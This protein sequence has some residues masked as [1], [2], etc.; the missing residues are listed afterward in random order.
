MGKEY[1]GVNGAE[2]L[3]C[4]LKEIK[5]RAILLIKS[6]NPYKA[7]EIEENL[8]HLPSDSIFL[9]TGKISYRTSDA[10]EKIMHLLKQFL[11]TEFTEYSSNP[12]WEDI[13]KG[14]K[15]WKSIKPSVIIALGGGSTLDVAKSIALLAE[16]NDAPEL[17]LTK[18]KKK[19]LAPRKIPFIAIPTTAGTGSEATYFATI[20]KDKVKLS[21]AHPSLL[22]DYVILDPLF[23]LSLSSHT[24]ACTGMDA[25]CQAIESYWSVHS[26]EESKQFAKRAIALALLNLEKAVTNPTIEVRSGMLKAANLAGKAINISFTTACHAVSYPITSYFGIPHGHAV[27]LTLPEM[28]QYNAEVTGEDCLD[29]RGVE[30]VRQTMQELFELFGV[31]SSEGMKNKIEAL[32]DNLG[33][34]RNLR[35]LGVLTDDDLNIIIKNGFN[36]DRVKNNPRKVSSDGL[37][38]I[39]KNIF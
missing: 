35:K 10:E 30:Y 28:I 21:L 7:Y 8:E 3:N 16:Q 4:L 5:P 2:E 1:F 11:L 38:K 27:A 34:E 25:L 12:L 37:L 23:T 36:P 6:K 14:V 19:I 33:L 17:Y 22:P 24:T 15:L 20:Y 26:T 29:K 18:E 9:S 39:L 13:I 32:M 31:E